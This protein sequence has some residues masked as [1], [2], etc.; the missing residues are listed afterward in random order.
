MLVREVIAALQRMPQDAVLCLSSDPGRETDITCEVHDVT[1]GVGGRVDL[2]AADIYDEKYVD[3]ACFDA[4]EEGRV[5]G[6][7]T[8]SAALADAYKRGR[9][10]GRAQK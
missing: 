8:T 2:V 5:D 3:R 9:R 7:H 6:E 1:I 4:Y 10:D